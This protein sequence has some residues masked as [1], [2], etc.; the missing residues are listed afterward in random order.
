MLVPVSEGNIQVSACAELLPAHVLQF[1]ILKI[2]TIVL[3]WE[4][5]MGEVKSR[6]SLPDN[7]FSESIFEKE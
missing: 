6:S 1:E 2:L 5:A 7:E 4:L 3:K